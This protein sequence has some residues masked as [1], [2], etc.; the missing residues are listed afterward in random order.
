MAMETSEISG[1][2]LAWGFRNSGIYF[3]W[4]YFCSAA[5]W[6]FFFQDFTGSLIQT[7]RLGLV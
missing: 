3:L 5:I 6:P 1:G 2:R 7:H 4:C